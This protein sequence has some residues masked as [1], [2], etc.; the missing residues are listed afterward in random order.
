[1][2]CYHSCKYCSHYGDK[3][4]HFCTSCNLKNNYPIPKYF[5]KNSTIKGIKNINYKK[6]KQKQ[7][8]YRGNNNKMKNANS[9]A[10][11]PLFNNKKDLINL[12]CIKK[13]LMS[14]NKSSSDKRKR[15]SNS[16]IEKWT[17]F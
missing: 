12:F 1:M 6:S 15:T 4:H 2:P 8:F 3:R 9:S 11:I 16:H 10:Y 17:K 13:I 5:L 14:E 7:T